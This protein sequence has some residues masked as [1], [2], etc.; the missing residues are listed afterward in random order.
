MGREIERKFLTA[1]DAW[2]AGAEGVRIRQGYL[3]DAP[4]CTVRVR[5]AGDRAWLT[6]K[7]PTRG[8]TRDEFE[9]P[10]PAGEAVEMLDR[11]CT[12]ILEKTRYR[13]PFGGR[14]WE[15]DEIHGANAGM[16]LAEIEIEGE[17][18]KVELPPW[19]GPEVTGDPRY[20]NSNLASK[21]RA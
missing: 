7:G 10:V 2:R 13:I 17:D 11:L 6:V 15:V 16:V 20:Y 18:A 9:Y 19:I 3:G 12:A 4:A 14:T 5:L 1:S 21:A 8:A